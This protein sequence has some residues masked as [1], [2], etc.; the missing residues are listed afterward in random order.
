M[1]KEW[2][3]TANKSTP[4]KHS[5]PCRENVWQ[6]LLRPNILWGGI[7]LPSGAVFFRKK[8]TAHNPFSMHTLF[9][10]PAYCP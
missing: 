8:I 3:K 10:T 7:L 4:T 1:V 9:S 5:H 2:R 6:Q